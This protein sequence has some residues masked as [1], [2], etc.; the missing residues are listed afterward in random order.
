MKDDSQD[1]GLNNWEIG[2]TIYYDGRWCG[3]SKFRWTK[4][5]QGFVSTVSWAA[6]RVWGLWE[7]F[8]WNTNCCLY[9]QFDVN[10]V[11]DIK[12]V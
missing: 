1:F 12:C 7:I 10:N 6:P 4:G 5:E 9:K 3:R 2:A 11:F 8:L